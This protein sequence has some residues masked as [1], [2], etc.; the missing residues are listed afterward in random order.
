VVDG[1]GFVLDNENDS[2]LLLEIGMI[3]TLAEL[4]IGEKARILGF[5]TGKKEYQQKLLAM[6][7]VPNAEIEVIRVAPL[8][9][10]V[11]I[12]VERYSLCLRKEESAI[13]QLERIG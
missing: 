6:G 12:K 3:V 10:P 13:L 2:H 9:D 1:A 7:L 5:K 4:H 8:G 11:E